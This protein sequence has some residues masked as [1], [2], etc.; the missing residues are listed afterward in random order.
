MKRGVDREKGRGNGRE[1][2]GMTGVIDRAMARAG[3]SDFPT[4]LNR[5]AEEPAMMDDLLVE[6]TI[7]ETYFFRNPEHFHFV[8]HQVLP[9]VL[10]RRGPT[11]VL[12]ASAVSGLR[13]TVMRKREY[14]RTK[15]RCCGVN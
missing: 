1:R 3:L 15:R 10:R 7:G 9:D 6:L 2:K 13:N 12:L 14:F 8:R 11:H 5:L 4:Y